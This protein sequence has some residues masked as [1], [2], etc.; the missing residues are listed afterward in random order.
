[1]LSWRN[2]NFVKYLKTKE[3]NQR[4]HSYQHISK[5]RYHCHKFLKVLHH[6]CGSSKPYCYSH[7]I[8]YVIFCEIFSSLAFDPNLNFS[9]LNPNFRQLFQK[10]S[11]CDALR[12]SV[13]FV[14]FKKR[15]KIP[16][17]RAT[18]SKVNKINTP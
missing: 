13:L 5:T 9:T 10:I 3:T 2:S 18:F 12:D 7:Y 17:R 15:E 11:I 1:M 16:W 6:K 8:F 14:Q 4:R